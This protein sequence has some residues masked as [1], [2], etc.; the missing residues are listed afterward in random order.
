MS[1]E[2]TKILR[3]KGYKAINVKGGLNGWTG[4]TRTW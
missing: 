4:K 3:N 1:E 2:A